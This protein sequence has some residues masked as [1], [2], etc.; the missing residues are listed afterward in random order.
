[1]ATAEGKTLMAFIGENDTWHGK[2]LHAAILT[3]L[4]DLGIAGATVL[5]GVEGYGSH[6]KIHTANVL[7]LSEGL[8]LVIVAVDT[9]ERIDQAVA[10]LQEM[11]ASGLLVVQPAQMI[12][13]GA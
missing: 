9:A 11:I 7:F 2:P 8:P 5:R 13:I 4:L 6:H 1:M 3:K 10:V 12:R